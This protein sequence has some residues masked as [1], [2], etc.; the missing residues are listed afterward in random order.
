M[1]IVSR[2]SILVSVVVALS[3]LSRPSEA[4]EER[5]SEPVSAREGEPFADTVDPRTGAMTYGY[6]FRN[7]P[8]DSANP[9]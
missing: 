5:P 6:P 3:L 8:A 9:V 7:R 2:S 4:D 1:R